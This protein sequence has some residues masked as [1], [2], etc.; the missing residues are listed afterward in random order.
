[1]IAVYYNP[2]VKK[3]GFRNIVLLLASLFFY[4]W[5]E[6]V[7]VF[8]MILS[9]IVNW[10][11]GLMVDGMAK[12]GNKLG[13]KLGMILSVVYNLGL[14]FVFKY[15]TFVTKNISFL[16]HNDSIVVNIALPIGISF[17]TFQLMS[18]VF[19]VYYG[20]AKVQKNLLYVG[21]YVSMFP[22]LIAGPIVRYET[23]A[24]EIVNRVENRKDFAEGF[25][26]FV[27]GL[28]KKIL[29]SNYVG[30]IADIAFATE[31]GMSVAMAWLG[32][33]AYTLQIYFDFSGYSDMAIGLGRMF[34][35]HFLENFNFPYVSKS[36]T[37]FWRRW[38]ITLSTWFRD[39]VYIPLGGNRVSKG[40][41]IWNIF[42]VWF[43]TGVWHGANWTF[44][45]WGLLYFVLLMFEKLTGFHKK[46]G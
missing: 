29:I 13:M 37:E 12:K 5:G 1:V 36:I 31:G 44:I 6:P 3:R 39:Y 41:H 8:L 11:F 9:I 24:D 45:C 30:K 10:A 43:L 7:F 40:R 14:M 26:R 34:G 25:G 22:Q 17:F 38:H 33:I 27:V 20:T 15:L 18:Y 19:D 42:V 32:A 16:L 28:G 35:F 23:V 2:F 46:N 21:L 4:G